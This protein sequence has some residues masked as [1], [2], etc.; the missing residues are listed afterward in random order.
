MLDRDEPHLKQIAEEEKYLA[1]E[2]LSP[3]KVKC[4]YH[5]SDLITAIPANKKRPLTIV[6]IE[7]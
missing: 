3:D 4:H 1:S 2:L 6:Q 7:C 5:Q